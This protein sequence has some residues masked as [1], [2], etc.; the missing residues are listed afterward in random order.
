MRSARVPFALRAQNLTN[1]VVTGAG[2]VLR[3]P[4]VSLAL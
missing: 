3:P 1:I 2:H 4:P